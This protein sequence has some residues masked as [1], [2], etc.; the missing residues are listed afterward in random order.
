MITG[1]P[2]QVYGQKRISGASKVDPREG[3]MPVPGCSAAVGRA[4]KLPR[5]F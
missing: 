2:G 3:R 1:G 5:R 4:D